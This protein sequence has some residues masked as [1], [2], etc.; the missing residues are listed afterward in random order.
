MKKGLGL[1]FMLLGL[2]VFAFLMMSRTQAQV[3]PSALGKATLID[4]PA[5]AQIKANAAM[6][7]EADRIKAIEEENQK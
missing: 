7:I 4:A 3:A 6:K 5:A 2:L 1:I